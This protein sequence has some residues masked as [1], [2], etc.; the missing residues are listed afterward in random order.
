[1]PYLRRGKPAQ[2]FF[3]LRDKIQR[4]AGFDFLSVFGD[5]MRPAGFVATPGSGAST[6]SRHK[7]GDAFDYNQGD[8]H[9]VV[10]PEP[11]NNDMFFRT[12]LRC[13]RQDGTQGVL[14]RLPNPNSPA[15][16]YCDFTTIAEAVGWQRIRAQNGWQQTWNK[17]EFWHY[18]LTEGYTYDEAM[19]LLYGNPNTVTPQPD[20]PT[21]GYGDR[22]DETVYH[23]RRDVRQVQAQL[24]LLRYLLPLS[25]IDGVF[26]QNTISAIG[27]FQQDE[28]LPVTGTADTQTR[29]LLLQRVL[30]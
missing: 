3:V 9:L 10:I 30:A 11:R 27:R 23:S 14:L 21:V 18:Q 2:L 6:R 29:R 16:Y 17:R 22:D 26:G 12:F 28:A 5:M 24:F 13:A 20:Y 19:T 7:C 4:A 15:R 8:S 1:M 25:E